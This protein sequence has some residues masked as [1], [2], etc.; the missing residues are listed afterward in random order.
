MMIVILF[1]MVAMHNLRYQ[2]I[3]NIK[4]DMCLFFLFSG[5]ILIELMYMDVNSINVLALAY[6]GDS[7]YEVYVRD[8]LVK[9]GVA[10]I[11]DLH[12]LSI[13]YVSADSQSRIVNGL[14]N[15][16]FFTANE[17]DIIKRGRNHKSGH[18]S[19]STNI[20]NYKLATGLETLIGYLYLSDNIN[21]IDEIMERILI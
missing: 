17:V 12:K 1:Q 11:N 16:N 7:V 8:Y 20:V 6:L 21:R 9:T 19:K 2:I 3:N 5:I 10:K 4:K 13:K 14:I 18:S 15:D